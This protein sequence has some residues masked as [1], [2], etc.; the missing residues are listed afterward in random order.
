[1]YAFII[2][3]LSLYVVC[4]FNP[5]PTC[6]WQEL[7]QVSFLSQ[8]P[9]SF[10]ATKACLSRS[11]FFPTYFCCDKTFV[12]TNIC[13]DKHNFVAPNLLLLWQARVCCG[14]YLFLSWKALFCHSK[15]VFGSSC[16]WPPF[17]PLPPH[18]VTY[19]FWKINWKRFYLY[20]V[21]SWHVTDW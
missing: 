2:P 9:P 11:N 6:H 8:N 20:I 10:V 4:C 15:H 13:S 5:H 16:Q 21:L 19:R 7:P 14:K 3:V 1:M 17:P 18:T 12:T